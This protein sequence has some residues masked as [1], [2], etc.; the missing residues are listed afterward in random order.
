M[1]V[2]QLSILGSTGS[3]GTQALQVVDAFPNDFKIQAL[4]AGKNINLLKTQIRCYRPRYVSV[5]N[6]ALAA[7]LRLEFMAPNLQV[8]SGE[9]GAVFCA[10]LPEVDLVLSAMVGARGLRPTLAAVTAGKTVALANKEVLVTAGALV[11]RAAHANG[12]TILPVDSEHA[13][14]HQ[15]LRSGQGLAEVRRLVITG[16]GGSLRDRS[17]E[18]LA[19]VT[20]AEALRHPNWSMGD[21]ITIDSATLM[22]KGLEV[23]EA[24]HLFGIAAEKIEVWIHRQSIVHSMV[25]FCD[26]NVVAQLALPDMRLP[27]QYCLTYPKRLEAPWPRLK[28][29]DLQQLSFE[30]PDLR[31]FPCLELAYQALRRGGSAPATLNAANEVAVREFLEGRLAFTDIPR[32]IEA[33]L[34]QASYRA[35]PNLE[36]ILAC[37]QEARQLAADAF[38]KT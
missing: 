12:S 9:A 27:L 33:V 30:A 38:Q 4:V 7:E 16:S 29:E 31:R 25:E 37:D 20:P 17:K 15:C 13:A 24:H 18:S 5:A 21:K 10:S 8:L 22:N 28:L 14:L 34:M 35:E 23:I 26:G 1:S 11:L 3:I 2:R 36:D 19:S 32:L 6:E